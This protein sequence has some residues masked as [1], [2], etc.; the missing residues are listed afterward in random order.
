MADESSY[1][2]WGSSQMAHD[3]L[4][5]PP[6][7]VGILHPSVGQRA[8]GMLP[9]PLVGIEFRSV[10]GQWNDVQAAMIPPP[11]PPDL[12]AAIDPG[13]VPEDEAVTAQVAQQVPKGRS[14]VGAP[15]GSAGPRIRR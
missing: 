4:N 7:D 9:D 15:W 1:Q 5:L 10:R 6:Q 13:V 11:H 12:F 2:T 14:H 8:L 3:P